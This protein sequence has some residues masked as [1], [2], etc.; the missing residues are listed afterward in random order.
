MFKRTKICTGVLVALGGGVLLAGTAQ[1]QT[2]E[3]IEVTGSRIKAINTEGPSPITVLGAAEIRADGVRNVESLLNNLPQVFAD[4]GANV[5]NGSTGTAT[6]NLRGLGSDRTL[7][8]VNGRRMVMGSPSN[9]SP[10]LNQIP[11]ALI[12]RV[13][14]LTGGASAVYGSD[15]VAG[16]VN[17]ILN[18]KFE[19]VEIEFN[20]GFY[21]HKQQGTAGVA[22]LVRA[23]AATNPNEFKVPGNKGSDGK[24]SNLSVLIGGNFDGNKGNATFFFNWKK[25]DA[26]LQSERD[27]SACSLAVSAAGF[28]CGG[29]GTS[30]TGRITNLTSTLVYTTA[31]A[32]GTARRFVN[33]TDQYN[34]GPVNFYQR[35]SERYG[36]NATANYDVSKYAKV[37][38]EFSFHDDQTIAQIAPG[39]AFGSVHTVR[40]DNPLLSASWRTALGLTA[41]GQSTDI[42]LQRRNVEGGG[43]Q[44]EFRNSSFRTV[45]GVKGDVAKWSYDAYAIASKVIYSQSE[46]NY[47]LSPR[48]DRAMN[49]VN[50]GGVAT[51]QSVVDG[52]D[53][54]CVP[55]NPWKL[56]GVT[57]AQLAYLQ[58]PGFRKGSTNLDM[59]GV[60]VSSDLGEYGIK[61][62][63]AKSGVGVAFGAEH[64]QESLALFTDPSTTA[65]LLSGS[66]GPTAGLSG[67]YSVK[68][69]FGELRLPVIEG[70]FLADLLQLNASYRHSSYS[71]GISTDTSGLG[72]EWAPVKEAKFR[73]SFQRATR[74]PNLVE[75]FQAQGNNLYDNDADP[76][77]G[78]TPTA[79]LAQCQRTGVTAA[80]YGRIQD[81]PALQYN[82]LAGGNPKL[83]PEKAKSVTFGVV[84]T[85]IKDLSVSLDYFDIKVD[86]TISNIDPTTTLAKCLSTGNP[87]FCSLITRDRLGT[88]WLLP[89][90]TIVGT[91]LNL[92]SS[93]TQGVDL[94]LSYGMKVSGLGTFGASL[95][96]TFLKKYEVEEIAGDGSY[97]CVGLYG[98]NK[99]GSPNP[100][101]RHKLRGTWNTPWDVDTNVTWSHI[102]KVDIQTTSGN[103]KLTGVV[104]EVERTL[105]A[106]NYLDVQAS[107]RATK[108]LTLSAGINNLLDKDPPIAASIPVGQGN[109]NT[110]P[111]V[112]DAL[113]RKVFVTAGYRF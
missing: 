87:S 76:C 100:Q 16:V 84:L 20:H 38:G 112:Y 29:S 59:Q 92:G 93:R 73:A 17:F 51:C 96:A 28:S 61:L 99:C 45:L 41:P 82:F 88:L 103:P 69:V 13:E 32:A 85:P 40:F 77:A 94:G 104:R 15:A 23:R 47:F 35:P 102:S 54:A 63:W 68:D 107:W 34:F 25:D 86:K 91:N 97:D 48:I 58:T 1:A 11:A 19:G 2:A 14:L 65:G 106:Q 111:S 21:N 36:A 44:S 74:A 81:S 33:A 39:G 80:Q 30:A 90:A 18:D 66:G 83:Q 43:R 113:G 55:Y 27:F 12:K 72:V 60:S 42:V 105:A 3:R 89:E 70:G 52:S 57:A 37:Y 22:D 5:V 8:L 9:T 7:V 101:Y 109:G 75:L 4:Q 78:A 95:A 67:E 26:L 46:N 110:F 56:G 53:P 64:R 79:T 6:V 98:P 108:G 31:D 62:P 24:S 50:V 49:I 10:D 71:T